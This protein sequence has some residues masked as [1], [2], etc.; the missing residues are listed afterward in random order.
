MKGGWSDDDLFQ[1]G[2]KPLEFTEDDVLLIHL[3]IAARSLAPLRT[4][5]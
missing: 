2:K 5:K 3:G 4:A 1:M